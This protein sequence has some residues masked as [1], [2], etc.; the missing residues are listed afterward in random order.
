MPAHDGTARVWFSLLTPRPGGIRIEH[1]ALAYD[2]AAAARAMR[3]AGLAEGYAA[4]LETGLWPSEDVLPPDERARLASAQPA[5]RALAR[6]G[7]AI[8]RVKPSQ[9]QRDSA[10]SAAAWRRASSPSGRSS[11]YSSH[12]Q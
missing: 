9:T 2:H 11:R 4:A 10:C 8:A 6:I 7:T 12:H 5:I 1:R 3:A